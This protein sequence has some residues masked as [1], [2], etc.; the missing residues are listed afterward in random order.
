LVD[1]KKDIVI[2]G[3]YNIASLEVEDALFRHPDVKAAAVI[4]IPHPELGEDL[5]A[6]IVP[7]DGVTPDAEALRAFLLQELSD[8]KVP[9]RYEWIADDLPRNPM[10]KVLKRELRERYAKGA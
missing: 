4:G 8:Y 5:V 6:C 9:R 10:G 7:Q 2:R 1:R 3:G